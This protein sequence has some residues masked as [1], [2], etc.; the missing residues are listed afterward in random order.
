[1]TK[2]IG[3]SRDICERCLTTPNK[4]LLKLAAFREQV[5]CLRWW[6][7]LVHVVIISLTTTR[8][9]NKIHIARNTFFRLDLKFCHKN[10][11]IY[12]G[13]YRNL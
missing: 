12:S 13:F 4:V 5:F 8:F 3:A 1:M 7:L 10:F 2:L 11:S 9:I 6:N